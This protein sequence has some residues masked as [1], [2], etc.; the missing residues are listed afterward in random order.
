MADN[1]ITLE[2]IA[3]EGARNTAQSLI[4]TAVTTAKT[5][6]E[7]QINA[8]KSA[9]DTAMSDMQKKLDDMELAAAGSGIGAVTGSGGE[10]TTR[11]REL[12]AKREADRSEAERVKAIQSKDVEI[13]SLKAEKLDRLKTEAVAAG[14]PEGLIALAES[15]EALEVEI[16]RYKLYRGETT[17]TRQ[18]SSNPTATTSSAPATGDSDALSAMTNLLRSAGMPG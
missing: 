14:V 6:A 8:L 9:H 16:T 1:D 3:D 15:P 7:S 17:E 18:P 5:D 4:N 13:Q 10:L 11:Q 2:S 12:L